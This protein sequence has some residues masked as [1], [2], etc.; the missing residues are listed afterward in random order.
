M[1][2]TYIF[3][4]IQAAIKA[5]DAI[6]AIY[7]NEDFG[8]EF[9]SDQSPLTMADKHA[10]SIIEEELLPLYLPILSEEGKNIPYE[11][12]KNW[13]KYWLVDPLDGTKE[14]INKNGEFTVNIAL[15]ENQL[16]I[17]GIIII[18]VSREIYFSIKG[19][20]SFYYENYQNFN[21]HSLDELMLKSHLLNAFQKP[22]VY[23]LIASRSHIN[24]ATQAFINKSQNTHSEIH[25]ISKGSSLKFCLMAEGKANV[26]PR[27]GPTMEW[28]TAAGHAIAVEAGCSVY[29]E[30]TN[31]SVIYNKPELLNPNFIVE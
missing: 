8:I 11:I 21:F 24:D 16:P 28:D 22:A 26:Y 6:L 23:T 18:P 1:I 9:K 3:T 2:Q 27:F 5:S 25:L 17:A 31:Q 14:F 10:H 12:R 19:I 13:Q 29:I 15:I 4:A 20:G 7:N 30:N